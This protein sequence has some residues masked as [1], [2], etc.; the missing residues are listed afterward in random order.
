MILAALLVSSTTLG[1]AGT[2]SA[3][4]TDKINEVPETT[5][6]GISFKSGDETLVGKGPF[7]SYLSVVFKPATF[8][9]GADQEAKGF[10]TDYAMV[11]GDQTV[12]KNKKFL[13]VNDDRQ[14]DGKGSNPGAPWNVKATYSG[15]TNED[16]ES[17]SS[18]IEFNLAPM[19]N[20]AIGNKP[21]ADGDIDPVN[22]MTDPTALT[23][24]T[25]EEA[26]KF[27][28]GAAGAVDATDSATIN[29]ESG[30]SASVMGRKTLDAAT[31]TKGVS[32]QITAG[33]LSI[34]EDAT[35]AEGKSYKGTITWQLVD[36]Y[37]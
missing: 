10:A 13:V 15:L 27:G 18:A 20:Y 16:S 25:S 35:K 7:K 34:K 29:I 32:S 17:L 21:T 30:A 5:D 19:E 22:P 9:F 33:K 28:F 4:T 14:D 3:N 37:Q 31:A 36:A 24:L 8:N 2:V 1:F 11:M 26:A 23:A 12:Q 6:V